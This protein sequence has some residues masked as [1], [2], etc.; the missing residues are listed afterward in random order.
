[1]AKQEK[2][3][4][5][6]SDQQ[7][8]DL[9]DEGCELSIIERKAKHVLKPIADIIKAEMLWRGLREYE[10]VS[11]DPVRL[12]EVPRVYPLIEIMR[13][14]LPPSLLKACTR[15]DIEWHLYLGKRLS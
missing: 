11:G 13:A 10:S 9:V 5:P 4:E 3:H 12:T 2:A 6:L 14:R 15:E 8:A 1:M 7:F